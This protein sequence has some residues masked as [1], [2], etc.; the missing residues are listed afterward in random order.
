MGATVVLRCSAKYCWVWALDRF[1][2]SSWISWNLSKSNRKW[3]LFRG[4]A[5]LPHFSKW[6]DMSFSSLLMFY[7]VFA[8]EEGNCIA[9]E[10]KS[11]TEQITFVKPYFEH[12]YLWIQP[13]MTFNEL[14]R[15]S[16][17]VWMEEVWFF[18]YLLIF[19]AS[20]V[21][22]I[23]FSPHTVGLMWLWNTL[24][25]S[26]YGGQGLSLTATNSEK[27]SLMLLV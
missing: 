6:W 10:E 19:S 20:S 4:P 13:A 22:Q 18:F 11:E 23:E 12:L 17:E 8:V 2:V 27:L 3:E 5:Y 24:F 15:K 1:L 25:S 26:D 7:S 14:Q 16:F 21:L 9:A